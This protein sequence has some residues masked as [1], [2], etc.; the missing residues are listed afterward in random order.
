MLHKI[1]LVC[2]VVLANGCMKV[3]KKGDQEKPNSVEVVSLAQSNPDQNLD[4]EYELD[5]G[6]QK[7]RFRIP[8]SWP[9]S[10]VIEKTIGTEKSPLREVVVATRFW[11]D[12]LALNAKTSYRF[13]EKSEKELKLIDQIDVIPVLELNLDKDVHLEEIFGSLNQLKKIYFQRLE[14]K[15]STKLFIG[16]FKG[17]LQI[18]HLISD[19]GTIQTFP[20]GAR[21]QIGNGRSVGN[22]TVRILDAA[23]EMN[24]Y[25]V[26]ESGANG[27]NGKKPDSAL[28]GENG[29]NGAR[30]I[31]TNTR[32]ESCPLGTNQL[33]LIPLRIFDCTKSPEDGGPAKNGLQGYPGQPGGNGGSVYKVIF[34]NQNSD[35]QV[36]VYKRF[37]KKG[38]GGRGG[39]G[40]EPGNPG[41]GGDGAQNDFYSFMGVDPNNPVSMGKLIGTK[42]G[43]T[44]SPAALGPRG[45]QGPPGDPGFDGEDGSI[46]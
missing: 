18:D 1:S 4:F 41:Q 25:L 16:D 13:F 14:L 3:K 38:F 23:G 22:F 45:L 9:E 35:L 34:E 31:F 6:V 7:A 11:K 42:M 44:C 40:G 17:T 46:F 5:E 24:L 27:A 15:N 2:L 32:T 19:K 10:V 21:A 12:V 43:S 36:N 33:C 20:E 39:L 28:T 30:A 29:T 26:A 8:N 37:G